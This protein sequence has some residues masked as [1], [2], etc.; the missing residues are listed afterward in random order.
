MATVPRKWK[1][2]L[3]SDLPSDLAQSFV[4]GDLNRLLSLSLKQFRDQGRPELLVA[5]LV[6]AGDLERALAIGKSIEAKDA[7]GTA[8]F[9][10]ALGLTRSGRYGEAEARVQALARRKAGHLTSFFRFQAEGFYH[11]FRGDSAAAVDLARQALSH[12]EASTDDLQRLTRVLSLDLLGHSL[13]QRGSTREGI[14]VLRSARQAAEHAQH[15]GFQ[16]A[17]DISILKY[18]TNFGFT[19]DRVIARLY[20]AMI[21]LKPTDSYSRSELRLELAKQLVFRGQLREAR[22]HL[23]AAAVD[24]LGSKNRQQ[25]ALLHF[26]L[27]WMARL[28]RRSDAGLIDLQ[29]AE[30]GLD[31]KTDRELLFKIRHLRQ[32]LLEDLGRV[33]PADRVRE[34][35]VLGSESALERRIRKRHRGEFE[36]TSSADD[37]FGHKLDLLARNEAAG[38]MLDAGYYGLVLFKLGLSLG[39]TAVYLGVPGDRVLVVDRGDVRPCRHGLTGLLGRLLDHLQMGSSTRR[40]AIEKV[41][42]YRYEAERHDRL[43]AVAVTRIRKALGGKVPWIE[44]QGDRMSLLSGVVVKRWPEQRKAQTIPLVPVLRMSS[45]VRVQDRPEGRLSLRQTMI[46]E[47][48][49]GANELG[50]PG[51][52]SGAIGV[53]DVVGRFKVSRASALRDLNRLVASGHLRRLGETRATRYQLAASTRVN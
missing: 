5:S 4:R 41:W 21:E 40:D 8:A 42:G 26:R 47:S 2:A 32:Q 6:L 1:S 53:A 27:A 14:R 22:S 12:A 46:L 36:N 16:H 20:R 43:L 51:G 35:D 30:Q 31:A 19:P 25:T 29:A 11:F 33:T 18:E 24:I 34:D 45:E 3:K 38:A 10:L 49:L 28:E 15:E 44:L 48:L 23:E 37:P 13:V 50:T 9:F 39:E 52:T 7:S 17:I